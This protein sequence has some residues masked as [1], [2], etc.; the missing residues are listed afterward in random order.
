MPTLLPAFAVAA[1]L[2]GEPRAAGSADPPDPW[3]EAPGGAL[4]PTTE[5]E[6]RPFGG[7]AFFLEEDAFNLRHKSDRNYTGGGAFQLSGAWVR[8]ARL[9]RPLDALDFVFGVDALTRRLFGLPAPCGAIPLGNVG[10]VQ[11]GYTFAFGVTAFTPRDLRSSA[12]IPDDRPYASLDFVT[13]SRSFASDRAGLALSS[14]VTLAVLGLREAHWIQKTI[15]AS[16]RRA[17]GCGGDDTCSPPDPKGWSHQISEGGELTGR[18]SVWLEKRLSRL[19]VLRRLLSYDLKLTA[20]GELGYYTAAALGG[21]VRLGHVESP[22]WSY[23]TAPMEGVNQALVAADGGRDLG[24]L[25]FE[26]YAWAGARGRFTAYNALLQGQFRRSTVT[27]AGN[28]IER[29][30]YDYEAGVTLA[31]RGLSLAWAIF[32][33]RSPEISAGQVRH[34]VWSSFYLAWRA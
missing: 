7:V 4:L 29:F 20:R 9:T 21:A 1:L 31:Y 34:H 8:R 18:Y 30:Q 14:D 16:M 15:H 19:D 11:K 5:V 32:Q 27:F 25:G 10:P 3:A 12:P 33:G 24:R 23:N 13:V 26:L 28:E 22:F 2:A 17:K 6:P